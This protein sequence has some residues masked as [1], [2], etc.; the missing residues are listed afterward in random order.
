MELD[1][2]SFEAKRELAEV[3]V[4]ISKGRA[5]LASIEAEKAVYFKKRED[6]ALQCV[7]QALEL[8]SD[9]VKQTNLYKQDLVDFNHDLDEYLTFLTEL[10]DKLQ[11]QDTDFKKR[12]SELL[13][14]LKDENEKLA[15][16][17]EELK[18]GQELL[19]GQREGLES[20][21]KNLNIKE[22]QVNDKYNTLERTINRL[23]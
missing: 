22:R 18:N 16:A 8:A 1:K 17:N 3:G 21:D 10:N 14:R 5:V 9:A 13:K 11:L 6:E 7:T 19:R 4:K 23:K 12:D 20:K 15:K 2:E